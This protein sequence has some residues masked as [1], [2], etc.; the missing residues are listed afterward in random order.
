MK[1]LRPLLAAMMAK[2]GRAG[3]LPLLLLQLLLARGL[4]RSPM[5]FI[6]TLV[7]EK[8]LR[9]DGRLWGMDLA[10]R[11]KARIAWLAGLLGHRRTSAR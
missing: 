5:G 2:R 9:G 10:S 11:R 3:T 7:L 6:S 1:M 4:R 8:A